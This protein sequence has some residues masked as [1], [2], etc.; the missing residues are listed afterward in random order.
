VWEHRLGACK[1]AQE[2]S[3][4]RDPRN[5]A[6]GWRSALAAGLSDWV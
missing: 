5:S 2:Y 3:L 6:R 4:S 1:C